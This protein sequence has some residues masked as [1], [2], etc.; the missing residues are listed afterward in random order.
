[1]L[2]NS[3]LRCPWFAG[4]GG[5]GVPFWRSYESDPHPRVW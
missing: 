1:L 5:P 2:K 4:H 3:A